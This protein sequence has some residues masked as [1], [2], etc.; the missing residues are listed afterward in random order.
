V[1]RLE[2]QWPDAARALDSLGVAQQKQVAVRAAAIALEAVGRPAPDGDEQAVTA[3]VERL[4]LV[5]WDI[6]D[7]E[8]AAPDA[9][10]AAFRRA[11]AV[12]A[13]VLA[14]F[15]GRPADAIFEALHALGAPADAGSVLGL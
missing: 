4:D 14:R 8:A 11:R 15:G 3:E 10:A 13:Y 2:H 1:D 9:Y 5:A 6:Q 7:N 12:N